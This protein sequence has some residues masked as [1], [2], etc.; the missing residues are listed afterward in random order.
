MNKKLIG[1]IA[2]TVLSSVFLIGCEDREYKELKRE[3]VKVEGI[4]TY[5]DEY[6]DVEYEQKKDSK[7]G[8]ITEVRDVDD[9]V[10]VTIEFVYKGETYT[11]EYS[12]EE[13]DDDEYDGACD[14]RE[15]D[16]V[17]VNVTDK[18][19]EERVRKNKDEP[20]KV[21]KYSSVDYEIG[22]DVFGV[23]EEY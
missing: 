17:E 8:K 6:E 20:W 7:T 10:D 1:I 19:I 18:L 21:S 13:G 5:L 2:T 16:P 4:V 14:L 3:D 9:M 23:E 12:F 22:V 11:E 15:G